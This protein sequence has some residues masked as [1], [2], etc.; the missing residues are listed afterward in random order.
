MKQKNKKSSQ[1]NTKETKAQKIKRVNA[2]ID[3]NLVGLKLYE[4]LE[5]LEK[6]RNEYFL[7]GLVQSINE[8]INKKIND[9]WE[10]IE[11]LNEEIEELKKAQKINK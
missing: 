5:F 2:Y 11:T 6:K 9:L 4:S 3:K 10:V 8:S 1:A 7:E